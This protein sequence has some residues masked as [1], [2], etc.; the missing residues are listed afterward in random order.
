MII[1]INNKISFNLSINSLYL[2]TLSKEISMLIKHLIQ[3]LNLNKEDL[4]MVFKFKKEIFLILIF[5]YSLFSKYLLEGQLYQQLINFNK[6]NR[7]FKKSKNFKLIRKNV[8]LN[9]WLLKDFKLKVKERNNKVK[10]E[11]Y[12]S[13]YLLRIKNKLVKR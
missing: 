13:K 1:I 8:T 2:K 4:I 7:K 5:K 11:Y 10:E 3:N 9:L 12:K 6:K